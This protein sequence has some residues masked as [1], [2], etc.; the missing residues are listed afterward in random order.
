MF[1]ARALQSTFITSVT[2]S[3]EVVLQGTFQEAW[4]NRLDIPATSSPRKDSCFPATEQWEGNRTWKRWWQR[5][6]QPCP[7]QKLETFIPMSYCG[8]SF[9]V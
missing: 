9:R 6:I 3:N 4:K 7:E 8:S 1:R 5:D 2:A